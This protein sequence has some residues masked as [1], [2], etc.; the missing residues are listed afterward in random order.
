MGSVAALA[1]V[2]L[3]GPDRWT[4]Q[5]AAAVG[6]GALSVWSSRP[7]TSEGDPG[8]IVVDEAAGT[9]VATVGLGLVPAAVAFVA[10]RIVDATKVL[11]GISAA[12]RLPG[13][14][15]ITADD[16]LAGLY[17]LGIGWIVYALT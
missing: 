7:F 6:V 15:G 14:W 4:W 8:W 12:E 16:L 11:P 3:I 9:L 2:S 1:L 13:S 17:A 10:F 5:V